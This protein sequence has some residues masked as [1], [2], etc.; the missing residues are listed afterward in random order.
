MTHN[1][2]NNTK[3]A[4]GQLTAIQNFE[5][6]AETHSN[7]CKPFVSRD[8]VEVE[9]LL[10]AYISTIDNKTSKRIMTQLRDAKAFNNKVYPQMFQG[11]P[12]AWQS[13]LNIP[14][15]LS[16]AN[17][18]VGSLVD[19]IQQIIDN[20]VNVNHKFDFSNIM[21]SIRDLLNN[22]VGTAVLAFA[23]YVLFGAAKAA[24]VCSV[25]LIMINIENIKE[26]TSSIMTIVELLGKEIVPQ[27]IDKI[28]TLSFIKKCLYKI[29]KYIC[30]HSGSFS[31]MHS[32]IN[33]FFNSLSE[34][35]M[36][37]DEVYLFVFDISKKFIEW[38]LK[39]LGLNVRFATLF[40]PFPNA[41]NI[42]I[43]SEELIEKYKIETSK[44]DF[45]PVTLD[46]ANLID[47]IKRLLGEAQYEINL[48]ATNTKF[49]QARA[50]LKD[51]ISRLNSLRNEITLTGWGRDVDRI[52]PKAIL[53]MG[54]PGIGKSFLFDQ[55]STAYLIA[56]HSRLPLKDLMNIINRKSEF[57]LSRNNSDKFWENYNNQ[58]I[59]YLDEVGQTMTG[60][61]SDGSDEFNQFIQM[62]S[63]ND[64]CPNMAS[65]EKKGVTRFTSELIIGL[66]CT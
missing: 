56:K 9:I 55:I 34:K 30:P 32:C 66:H 6:R 45:C 42:C 43:S 2:L 38:V 14:S 19:S 65:I 33:S 40:D 51:T 48:N 59:I 15:A 27:G 46:M 36:E 23:L 10:S 12:G 22:R 57:V 53:V 1:D 29:W 26:V 35:D 18:N 47:D 62:V 20:G 24:A 49:S 54:A 61:V 50:N 58:P 5:V 64:F 3:T 28:L 16:E 25:V 21:D 17:N 13:I 8:N 37:K 63:I 60:G 52:E 31:S 11:L 4:Y 44:K 41:V 7:F 39:N